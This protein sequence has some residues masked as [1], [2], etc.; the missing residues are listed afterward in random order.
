M[1]VQEREPVDA[2]AASGRLSKQT[3]CL[4][5]VH[6]LFATANA[7]S[8]AFVNVYLWKASNNFS[9]IGWFALA[10]QTANA[11]TFMLAGKWVKEHDKMQSLRLGIAVSAAFYLI[12]LFLKADAVHYV[13]LLGAIQ[14]MGGG[15]FWL[16][17][18]VVYFEVTGPDNRDKFNGWAG[19]LGSVAG[20]V[21][22]WVS[23]FI[24]VRMTDN[25]GYMLIFSLSLTIFIL[26][27]VISFF[28]HKRKASGHYEWL[29]AFRQ[30]RRDSPWK[31]VVPALVAQGAREGVFAFIIALLVYIVTQNEQKLGTFSLITSAVALV[32]FW[33][34]GKWLKPRYRIKAMLWGTM[35]MMLVILPFYWQLSYTTL[36]LFGIGT[37]LFFPLFAVPMTS[38]VFD[39]IGKNKDSA[40]HKVEFVVLRELGLNMG[41]VAGTLLFIAVVLWNTDQWVLCTLLLVIGSA[42][43]LSWFFMKK[44]GKLV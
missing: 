33:L 38:T 6:G 35:V 21:A 43:I 34:V 7:L 22:P 14:G 41:R 9:L 24:I 40:S 18:N 37:A 29:Y 4:L 23:G 15:L 44:L 25:K 2:R 20:M 39:T 19:L 42:P 10:S 13:W 17:F 3:I 31:H 16:A 30:V 26:G 1:L 36:L 12:V 32:A 27:V 28:L 5:A 8:G 11:V